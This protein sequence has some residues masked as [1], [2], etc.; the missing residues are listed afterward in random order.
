MLQV[1]VYSL[2][3]LRVNEDGASGSVYKGL[4]KGHEVAIK[5][6]GENFLGFDQ[7]EFTREVAIMRYVGWCKY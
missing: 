1:V 2:Y 3:V 5:C 4:Y 7:T 6:T